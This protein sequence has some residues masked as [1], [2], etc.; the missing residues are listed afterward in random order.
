MLSALNIKI[1]GGTVFGADAS[2]CREVWKIGQLTESAYFDN[3]K[4]ILNTGTYKPKGERF[5]KACI[6]V[7]SGWY[8]TEYFW[9]YN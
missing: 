9:K 5:A 3:T 4:V 7:D 6:K 8:P 2:R 1:V